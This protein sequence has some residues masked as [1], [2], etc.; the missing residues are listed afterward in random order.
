MADGVAQVGS[1]EVACG[2]VGGVR[3]Q[4]LEDVADAVDNARAGRLIRESKEPACN[5]HQEY[6][7]PGKPAASPSCEGTKC[8]MCVENPAPAALYFWDATACRVR[9]IQRHRPAPTRHAA[10]SRSPTHQNWSR[11]RLGGPPT[12]RGPFHS[13]CARAF[14]GSAA[15]IRRRASSSI[16]CIRYAQSFLAGD[17]SCSW[18]DRQRSIRSSTV[19]RPWLVNASMT[20]ASRG[21]RAGGFLTSPVTDSA[22]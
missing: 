5:A 14:A 22:S 8:K 19:V 3:E 13:A 15:G 16:A 1:S 11:N 7:E 4:T 18:P 17:R 10:G 9:G 2:D 21:G 6:T 12:L 20:A